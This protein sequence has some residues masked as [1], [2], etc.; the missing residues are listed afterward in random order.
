MIV[1]TGAAGF[2]GSNVVAALNERGQ[3]DIAVCDRLGSDGR[4]RNLRKRRFREFVFPEDLTGFLDGRNDVDAVIHLGANSSTTAS[5]GD[6]IVRSNLQYSTRLLDWCAWRGVPLV[7]ASSAATYGDG[8]AGFVDGLSTA[9]L[10]RLQPLNLYGWSKHQF[11]LIVAERCELGLPLPPKC[12]GLKFFNVFGQNE[13]HK[14]DMQS[15]VAKNYAAA[16]GGGEIRLFESHRAGIPHGGQQRDF[17]YVDDVVDVVL[18]CLDHGPAAG[19][20]NVGTGRATS[21]R[22]L[23]EALYAAAGKPPAIRYVPM[24][25]TLRPVYQYFTEASVDGLRAAGYQRPFTPPPEG[26]A[27]YVKYLA[28]GDP[29]R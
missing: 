4:W 24:P 27:R 1:V 26:V 3:T 19:L 8:S 16:A 20:F 13:Y 10:A 23:I 14:R 7:Y 29:Y 2:I 9:G 12:I 18:W 21:F 6:E 22:E 5:D 17:I 25:E 28:S 11:D 15:V